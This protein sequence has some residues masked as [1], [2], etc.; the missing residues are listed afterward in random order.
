MS[1]LP[2]NTRVALG[3]R[4]DELPTAALISLAVT[5]MAAEI[6]EGTLTIDQIITITLRVCQKIEEELIDIGSTRQ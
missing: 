5:K 6:G 2:G 1:R 3:P 4:A